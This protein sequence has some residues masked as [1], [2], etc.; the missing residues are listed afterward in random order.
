LQD[1]SSPSAFHATD[2]DIA[3]GSCDSY[4]IS[5]PLGA[6]KYSRVFQGRRL[7]DNITVAI[8][9]LKP[10]PFWKVEIEILALACSKGIQCATLMF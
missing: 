1:V 10:I 9:V 4:D 3:W 2:A 6:G 8:K 5:A 7:K